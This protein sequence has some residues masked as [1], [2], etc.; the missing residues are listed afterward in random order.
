[1]KQ[2][3][4]SLSGSTSNSKEARLPFAGLTTLGLQ[5]SKWKVDWIKKRS[6]MD[7][8]SKI[9]VIAVEPTGKASFVHSCIQTRL[10]VDTLEN[11]KHRCYTRDEAR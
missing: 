2:I 3:E 5:Q 6:R 4:E 1:M 7:N 8:T 9:A 10:K 11:E